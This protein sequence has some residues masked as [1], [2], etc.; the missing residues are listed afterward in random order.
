VRD[1]QQTIV[2]TVLPHQC[3]REFDRAVRRQFACLAF[4]PQEAEQG[5]VA[6]G[7]TGPRRRPT[8][9]DHRVRA[10]ELPRQTRARGSHLAPCRILRGKPQKTGGTDA[11]RK[12]G[13]SLCGK[14][15]ECRRIWPALAEGGLPSTEVNALAQPLDSPGPRETRKRLGNGR[16]RKTFEVVESPQALT[17]TFDPLLDQ[18][19]NAPRARG[20]GGMRLHIPIIGRLGQLSSFIAVQLD[21]W[22][23]RRRRRA[24]V[25]KTDPA[26]CDLTHRSADGEASYHFIGRLLSW[27]HGTVAGSMASGEPSKS[28]AAFGA[29]LVR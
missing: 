2:S 10:N 20:V 23:C 4:V 22:I 8:C 18:P 14:L 25:N 11:S 7:K 3:Q 26:Q 28:K 21:N 13:G 17:A 19:G 24:L 29:T 5:A 15:S 6:F 16:K 27:D 9:V 1:L 12:D